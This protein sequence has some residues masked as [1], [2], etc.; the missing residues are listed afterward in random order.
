METGKAQVAALK[1]AAWLGDDDLEGLCFAVDLDPE[2]FAE[3]SGKWNDYLALSYDE[4]LGKYETEDLTKLAAKPVIGA[5]IT[6]E[7][8]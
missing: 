7:T 3:G 5:V 6:Q 4:G 2:D 1:I 8:R